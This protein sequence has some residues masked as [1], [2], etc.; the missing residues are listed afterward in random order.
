MEK[1]VF[2]FFFAWEQG[3]L[4]LI[5]P[6]IVCSS[7]I[8]HWQTAIFIIEVMALMNEL[9]IKLINDVTKWQELKKK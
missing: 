6:K 4:F 9:Q 3:A 7:F 5:F 2:F 1:S 8:K